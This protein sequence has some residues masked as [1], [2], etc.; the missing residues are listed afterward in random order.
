MG[1][2]IY[3]RGWLELQGESM[4]SQLAAMLKS[5]K[6]TDAYLLKGWTLPKSES[7]WDRSSPSTWTGYAFYSADLRESCEPELKEQFKQI[8]CNL[9]SDDGIDIERPSGLMLVEHELDEVP[10]KV[11]RIIEGGF[12]E[13]I[14][15]N[16]ENTDTR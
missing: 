8:A 15:P 11:W 2:Y 1:V 16:L 13:Y 9:E 7:F 14:E 4:R 3:P 6:E 12:F 10:T 5:R